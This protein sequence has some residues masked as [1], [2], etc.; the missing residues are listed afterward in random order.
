MQSVVA[1]FH[2][3]NENKGSIKGHK[4]GGGA[5]WNGTKEMSG[6]H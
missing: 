2:G 3:K 5:D 1:V 6:K 4:W